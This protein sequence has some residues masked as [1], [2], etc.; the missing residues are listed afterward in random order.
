MT[1]TPQTPNLDAVLVPAFQGVPWASPQLESAF[2]LHVLSAVRDATWKLGV[3]FAASAESAAA[4]SRPV[5]LLLEL[6]SLSEPDF[7]Q[8]VRRA[9]LRANPRHVADRRD[10]YTNRMGLMLLAGFRRQAR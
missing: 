9:W 3:L 5:A 6:Q 7:H 8:V 1:K 10:G 4:Q 2:N